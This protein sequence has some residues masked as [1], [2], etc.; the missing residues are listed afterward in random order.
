[1]QKLA[2]THTRSPS[3]IKLK[4]SKDISCVDGWSTSS[5][6]SHRPLNC[7]RH[8]LP[9]V[10]MGFSGHVYSIGWYWKLFMFVWVG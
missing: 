8:G 7:N 1:M 9:S 4:D 6:V 10:Q 2:W 3:L 5:I